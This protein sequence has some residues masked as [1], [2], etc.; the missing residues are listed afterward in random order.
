M[1]G[2]NLCGHLRFSDNFLPKYAPSITPKWCKEHIHMTIY[3]KPHA[4]T[5]ASVCPEPLIGTTPIL[6]D[7]PLRTLLREPARALEASSTRIHQFAP[8]VPPQNPSKL[9]LHN[10]AL[11]LPAATLGSASVHAMMQKLCLLFD[12]AGTTPIHIK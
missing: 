10:V 6:S 8:T 5:T 3:G 12:S 4:D 7:T 11:E 2:Q 1:W 9:L